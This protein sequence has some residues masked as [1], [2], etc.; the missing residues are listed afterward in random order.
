MATGG[1]FLTQKLEKFSDVKREIL[2][3]EQLLA[4]VGQVSVSFLS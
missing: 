3:L 4:A 1:I 2:D